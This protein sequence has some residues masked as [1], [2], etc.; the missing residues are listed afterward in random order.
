[1]TMNVG[2][3]GWRPPPVLEDW[4]AICQAVCKGVQGPEWEKMYYKFVETQV[5]PQS[6][7]HCGKHT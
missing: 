3:S 1:M 6:R 7:K 2:D 5:E 4:H